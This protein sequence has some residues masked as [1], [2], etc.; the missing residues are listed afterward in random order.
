MTA[1]LCSATEEAASTASML[2][3]KG[4]SLLGARFGDGRREHDWRRAGGR[5][6]STCIATTK[7]MRKEAS[8]GSRKI[9]P[10]CVIEGSTEA[11]Q[12]PCTVV[13]QGLAAFVCSSQHLTV[14]VSF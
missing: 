12:Q 3:R 8:G 7:G 11:N 4:A 5:V 1:L 6:H 10:S 9:A 14:L 2:S 13:G